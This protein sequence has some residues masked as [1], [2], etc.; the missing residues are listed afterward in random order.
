MNLMQSLELFNMQDISQETTETLKK[1]Y[2]KL[3]VKYH[4]DSCGSD[5]VAKNVI[6]AYDIL[7]DA[8][9]KFQQYQALNKVQETITILLPLSKL[10]DIYNG[11]DVIMGTGEDAI[12]I[13]NKNLRKYNV[14]VISDITLTHNGMEHNYS[15]IE[16][17][18][19]NDIYNVQSEIF[20]D[21][22]N[23]TEKVKIRLNDS[24]KDINISVQSIMLKSTLAHNIKFN[25][26]INK[27]IKVVEDEL[28][29]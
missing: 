18:N 23:S 20:V 5:D 26:I 25:I 16:P 11:N 6:E 15:N 13:N 28:H 2:R 8:L 24:E 22:L 3:M 10:I 9:D 7:K 19:I 14:L 12:T 4:P 21:D 17:W 29:T 27:K 1:K